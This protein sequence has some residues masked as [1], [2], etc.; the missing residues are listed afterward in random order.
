MTSLVA[1]DGGLQHTPFTRRVQ[2]EEDN[3]AT[4]VSWYRHRARSKQS[5][6]SSEWEAKQESDLIQAGVL[7]SLS[8][9]PRR[10]NWNVVER[11]RHAGEPCKVERLQRGLRLAYTSDEHVLKMVPREL[12]FGVV[13]QRPPHHG[14]RN[15][16]TLSVMERCWLWIVVDRRYVDEH[17]ILDS[18]FYRDRFHE[19]V[20]GMVCVGG[21]G[22]ECLFFFFFF[23]NL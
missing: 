2:R 9:D 6:S 15:E 17:N 1:N 20:D 3:A 8:D 11:P 22:G 18:S 5:F 16:M 14:S 7:P 13:I 23:Y 21:Q 4:R 12:E 19:T 10:F